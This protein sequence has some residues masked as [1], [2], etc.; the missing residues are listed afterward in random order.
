MTHI[1]WVHISIYHSQI[2]WVQRNQTTLAWV[3][4][5]STKNVYIL[6]ATETN[7]I[8]LDHLGC[9][10][11]HHQLSSWRVRLLGHGGQG[12]SRQHGNPWSDPG[13]QVGPEEHWELWWWSKQ[14]LFS[15]YLVGGE[16][17]HQLINLFSS[18]LVK[19]HYAY[20]KST[21]LG[22]RWLGAFL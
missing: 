14:G 18:E 15:H 8:L 17:G 3:V 10:P 11:G 4:H 13:P 12:L 16:M 7:R 9:H 19:Q 22:Y 20:T 5:C 1:R 2:Y 21:V 6:E